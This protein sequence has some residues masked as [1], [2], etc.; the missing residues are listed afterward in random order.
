M[1]YSAT[2]LLNFHDA[3]EFLF[4]LILEDN[5]LSSNDFNFMVCFDKINDILKEDGK[6]PSILRA[7]LKK[8]K[9]RWVA[10][11]HKGSF[12][13]LQDIDEAKYT[14]VNLF[15]DFCMKYYDLKYGDI[16]LSA[17]LDDS[18]T[19]DCLLNLKKCSNNRE[20]IECL[21]LAFAYLLRDFESTKNIYPDDSPYKLIKER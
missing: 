12:P 21:A 20:I 11:K 18:K 4:D 9:D 6:V 16:D 5:N 15:E 13:S 10:L 2:S 14:T 8:L 17:L 7:S 1:P 3:L 19:K